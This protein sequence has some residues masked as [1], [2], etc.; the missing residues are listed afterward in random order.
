[1]KRSI[2][3]LALAGALVLGSALAAA[4]AQAAPGDGTYYSIPTTAELFVVEAVDG[5]ARWHLASF[6]EWRADGFPAPRP[7]AVEYLRYTWGDTIY[8]D[9]SADGISFTMQIDYPTWRSLGFSA[10]RT[11]RITADST[12]RAY[13]GSDELFVWE[14]LALSDS[15]VV[16]KLTFSEYVHLG[17]PRVDDESDPAFRKLA[18]NP[19]IVGPTDQAG[20]IGAVDFATWDFFGRPTPQ[21]VPSFDGDRFCQARGSAEIRYVGLAAP[22]GLALTY[23]QWVASGSPRP[24]AC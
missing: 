4:P 5:Q 16:H 13:T 9:V 11:D 10:P 19:S 6:D 3:A 22:E 20:G 17:Y 1:V 15:Y 21:V 7:P 8:Q 18:W 24:T 2:P 12:V 23:R 14:G